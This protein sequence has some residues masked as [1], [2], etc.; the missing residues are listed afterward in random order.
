M[1]AEKENPLTEKEQRIAKLTR[2]VKYYEQMH[3][4]ARKAIE[5]A[6]RMSLE[7]KEQRI[8]AQKNLERARRE[9]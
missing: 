9:P 6:G 7:M 2:A 1:S 4:D 8:E 3:A 5:I